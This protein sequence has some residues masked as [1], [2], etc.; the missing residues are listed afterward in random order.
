MNQYD[1]YTE[2]QKEDRKFGEKSSKAP[3]KDHK[4]RV[5]HAGQ[6]DYSRMNPRDIVAMSDDYA[7]EDDYAMA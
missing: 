3:A 1:I 6:Q 2:L 5:K 4:K 7:D